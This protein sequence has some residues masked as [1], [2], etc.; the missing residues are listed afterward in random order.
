MGFLR[1]RARGYR[2]AFRVEKYRADAVQLRQDDPDSYAQML[3]QADG[4]EAEEAARRDP[5][6]FVALILAGLDDAISADPEVQSDSSLS[7]A[8]RGSFEAHVKHV[9]Q[10]YVDL[11]ELLDRDQLDLLYRGFRRS[12][13]ESTGNEPDSFFS[14]SPSRFV[15]AFLKFRLDETGYT[16][17]DVNG[18]VAKAR[19]SGEA[20]SFDLPV[21]EGEDAE[22]D[23][24]YWPNIDLTAAWN[25]VAEFFGSLY[26]EA[27]PMYYPR[28]A[29]RRQVATTVVGAAADAR[30]DLDDEI[31]E[32]WESVGL[33][34]DN[35]L[36]EDSRLDERLDAFLEAYHL[37]EFVDMFVEKLSDEDES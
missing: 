29:V 16:L 18:L 14:D 3:A 15:G 21:L 30:P 37:G 10:T 2:A 6:A 31:S 28:W 35:F 11:A 25:S 23:I 32:A 24:D 34:E 19:A 33:G 9:P 12:F 8:K 20:V 7:D 5:D 26:A 22:H 27:G 36:A 17:D 1:R 13:K 4:S